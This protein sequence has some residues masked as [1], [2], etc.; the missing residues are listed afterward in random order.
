MRKPVAMPPKGSKRPPP[1]GSCLA[2][3]LPETCYRCKNGNPSRCTVVAHKKKRLREDSGVDTYKRPRTRSKLC[4]HVLARPILLLCTFN[5]TACVQVILR[6][7]NALR[8]R[9]HQ[10]T[11]REARTTSRRVRMYC[12]TRASFPAKALAAANRKGPPGVHQ[13]FPSSF[14]PGEC[15]S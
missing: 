8:G 7:A 9:R 12:V 4:L 11:P 1:E 3:D 14:H 6:A 13:R 15:T 5:P 2:D 10:G